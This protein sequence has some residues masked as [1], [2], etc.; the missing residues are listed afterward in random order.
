MKHILSILMLFATSPL[1]AQTLYTRTGP[2]PITQD[3]VTL[4]AGQFR[5][6][7]QWQKSLDNA[8]WINLEGK[9]TNILKVKPDFEAMYRAVITEG[10]C[11]PIYSDTAKIVF[12]VPEVST[13]FVAEITNNSALMGGN[14]ISNGGAAISE[15]GVCYSLSQ[16]PT[17]AGSKVIMGNGTGTFKNTIT[18]LSGNRNYFVRAYAKNSAG[19][20]YGNEVSFKTNLVPPTINTLNVSSIAQTTATL[21]GN[22]TDDGGAIITA[23]GV[24]WGTNQNP[25][26]AGSKTSDCTGSGSFSSYLNGLA[27]NTTYYVR[28][29][30]ANSEGI[31]YGN[32]ETF[33]TKNEGE[34]ETVLDSDGNVYHTV[35]IGTQVW[36]AENL[37]STKYNDGTIIPNVTDNET[38]RVSTSGEYCWYNNNASYKNPYGALYNWHTVNTEKLAPAGWHVPSDAEWA[39][40]INYLGGGVYGGKLK[41]SGF[42]HWTVNTLEGTN[43]TGFTAVPGGL[44]MGNGFFQVFSFSSFWWSSTETNFITNSTNA[45]YMGLDDG[46]NIFRK[47]E[48]QNF[49]YS[50]RCV[51]DNLS[52]SCAVIPTLTTTIVSNITT[53]SALCIG[54]VANDGGAEVIMRGACWNTTGNPTTANS[55][56]TSGAGNGDYGLY[57]EGLAP[58]TTYFIRAFATN[59]VGTAYG[60][61]LSFTTGEKAT[62]PTVTTNEIT[63]ITQTS[64]NT[65]GTIIFNGYANIIA[66]GICWDIKENPTT[67]NSKTS[68]GAGTDVY[69]SY[70]TGLSAN[71]TYYIRSYATNSAGTG[72]GNQITFTTKPVSQTGTVTDIDGNVYHT[73]TIGNQVWMVENLR[74]TKFNDGTSIPNVTSNSAW[75]N[76]KTPGYCWNQNDS[77][78]KNPYGA[79]YNWYSVNTGKLAPK[80]WH[81]PSDAEWKILVDFLGNYSWVSY[82]LQEPGSSHWNDFN[83]NATNETGFTALPGGSRIGPNSGLPGEFNQI[84]YYGQWWSSSDN[85]FSATNSQFMQSQINTWETTKETG[86]SVRCL[87][88]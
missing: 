9:N 36:M 75:S 47:N 32:E 30:A 44:R 87:R 22:V 59:S 62:L 53:T 46:N 76:L 54:N 74:V 1:F 5:G 69:S 28:A 21:G 43:E 11:F 17:T 15:R 51:K 16:K 56:N 80:G 52:A 20:S 84:G 77:T 31:V 49:G 42:I 63:A 67:A 68:D 39:T 6:N 12:T 71:T 88:D 41:E 3:S 25:T 55:I 38:W 19:T 18:G 2:I 35:T 8:N 7:I 81:V 73:I 23:R 60:N 13:S 26:V 37:K 72:Y 29:Y 57:L 24:C 4:Q 58:N 50:V 61:E 79:L 45:W 34:P 65:G 64:A 40:L 27:A 66:R 48:Y 82:K 10:T 70:L 33:K 83:R 86:L 14:V 78:Y 85:G